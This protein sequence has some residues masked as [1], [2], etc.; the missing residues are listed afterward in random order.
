M[1]QS[2]QW[3]CHFQRL[4]NISKEHCQQFHRVKAC[5]KLCENRESSSRS[6]DMG[7]LIACSLHTV[8]G[9]LSSREGSENCCVIG[10]IFKVKAEKC[11]TSHKFSL[12]LFLPLRENKFLCSQAVCGR[13][14][15]VF[16]LNFS[17]TN[18]WL[19]FIW[20]THPLKMQYESSL[21]C[22][23]FNQ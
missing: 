2:G 15:A 13:L 5:Y 22:M 21:R 20:D 6:P 7:G 9:E 17:N 11:R 19:V 10:Q 18:W 1:T 3:R 23:T 4:S 8:P 12:F 14:Y 16:H